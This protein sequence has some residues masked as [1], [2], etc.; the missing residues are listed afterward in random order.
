MFE[1][2]W[3]AKVKKSL[4]ITRILRFIVTILFY[5]QQKSTWKDMAF[6]GAFVTI[7]SPSCFSGIWSKSSWVSEFICEKYDRYKLLLSIKFQKSNMIIVAF[8]WD[9]IVTCF[10]CHEWILPDSDSGSLSDHLSD[11]LQ[12]IRTARIQSWWCFCRA[13]HSRTKNIVR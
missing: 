9:W 13:V 10:F 1:T 2:F 3:Q 6:S 7:Q 11:K 8:R 5:S 12:R 4:Y